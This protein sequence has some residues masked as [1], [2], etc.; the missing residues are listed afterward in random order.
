M[1]GGSSHICLICNKQ[2]HYIKDIKLVEGVQRRATK[3]LWGTENLQ[4]E[5][6]LKKLEE[7]DIAKDYSRAEADWISFFLFIRNYVLA[8]RIVR[9]WNVLP[10]SCTICTKLNDFKTKI[11]LQLEPETQT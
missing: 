9:K 8:N 1:T 5:E 11:K 10:D 6:R 2:L 7:G 3:L 4:Y